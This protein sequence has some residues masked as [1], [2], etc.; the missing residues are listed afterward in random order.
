MIHLTKKKLGTIIFAMSSFKKQDLKLLEKLSRLQLDEAR[1]EGLL[2][3]LQKILG[4][5]EMLQE[6]DTE[7]TPPLTHVIQSMNAPCREDEIKDK[8][9]TESF[10]EGAPDKVG[11]FL[12]VP[13]VIEDKEE[14]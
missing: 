2:E 10:L 14:L 11:A 6:A 5:M 13:V 12:K 3:N 4:Y 1:E 9:E 8:F 7:N